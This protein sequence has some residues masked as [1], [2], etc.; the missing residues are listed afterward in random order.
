MQIAI[1][2]SQ[3]AI[4]SSTTKTAL[5]ISP[6]LSEFAGFTRGLIS[7]ATGGVG[8]I[9]KPTMQ[10]HLYFEPKPLRIGEFKEAC[11]KAIGELLGSDFTIKVFYKHRLSHGVE[12]EIKM[13]AESLRPIVDLTEADF[14][15][16]ALAKGSHQYRDLWLGFHGDPGKLFGIYASSEKSFR[17]LER[18]ATLLNL[19]QTEA[20]IGQL[21]ALEARVAAL[22]N[23]AREAASLPK[24]FISFKFDDP[25]T[26]TQV[27]RLKRLLTA[28][29]I[30]FVTGEL[31][32]PQRI[33]DKVKAR[34]RADL[35][36]LIAVIT[37]AG[38]SKWIRDEIA[39]ANARGLWTVI[40]LQEGATFDK[41][42]FGTLEY[43]RHAAAIEETFP[44][45]LE[46]INFIK[47]AT[48][49]DGSKKG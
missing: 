46:G 11:E 2:L 38:E 18:I 37:K 21:E 9:L 13:D 25:D 30:E 29:H 27:N 7:P 36:F 28:V 1:T 26:V 33:E 5:F 19:E 47:A 6:K 32:E 48:S 39:D 31:F 8:V 34:L 4:K 41:G 3:S 20:P 17:C 14:T 43:I 23:A 16:D 15:V 45:V 49:A 24:C 12:D 40:L 35:A 10:A 42:I 44:A 22:E